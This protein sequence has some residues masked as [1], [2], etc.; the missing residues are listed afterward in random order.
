M[1]V[2]KLRLTKNSIPW[3]EERKVDVRAM[4]SALTLLFAELEPSVIT[5]DKILTIQI[6]Y[7]ADESYYMFLTDKLSICD[8]PDSSAKSRRQK[9]AAFFNHFL[10]EFRHWMQSRIY[11]INGNKLDYSADDV[12]RNTNAYFRNEYEVDARQFARYHVKKF[13]RYYNL[14]KK[15]Y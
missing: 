10:H 14:F 12:H 3:F 8:E 13:T 7:G 9:K 1:I 15:A 2:F 4:E 6:R 5:K 11:K